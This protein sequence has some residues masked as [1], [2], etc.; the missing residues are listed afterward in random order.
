MLGFG[1]R[2]I[3]T[4]R[5]SKF[6]CEQGP[7]LRDECVGGPQS[8]AEIDLSGLL[9]YSCARLCANL[10]LKTPYN[11]VHCACKCSLACTAIASIHSIHP[12]IIIVSVHVHSHQQPVSEKPAYSARRQLC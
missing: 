9:T 2:G 8:V 4:H 6:S 3:S 11:H 10:L 1:R 12:T 5:L 7:T